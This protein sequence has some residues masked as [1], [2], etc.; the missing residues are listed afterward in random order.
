MTSKPLSIIKLVGATLLL[1]TCVSG[2]S[3][4]SLPADLHAEPNPVAR[5]QK[6]LKLAESAFND[7]HRF[8]AEGDVDKGDA[9]LEN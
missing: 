5:S 6:A 9:Q 2:V 1:T 3:A 8:Y 4:E 7:A